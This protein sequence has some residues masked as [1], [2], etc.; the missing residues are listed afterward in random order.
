MK[1]KSVLL[2]VSCLMVTTMLF[3][4]CGPAAEEKE[5]AVTPPEED[6]V[7]AVEEE[8]V[9]EEELI[10]EEEEVAPPKEEETP[11]AK[12]A[13]PAEFRIVGSLVISPAEVTAG[14]SA[15][16]GVD[17]K[18][19]GEVAGTYTVTLKVSGVETDTKTVTLAGGATVPVRFAVVK[20]TVGIHNIQVNSQTGILKV[21]PAPPARY[22]SYADWENGFYISY[23]RGWEQQEG[24]CGLLTI[25]SPVEE[26]FTPTIKVERETLASVM[27][28]AEV[29]VTPPF[30]R[31]QYCDIQ[32]KEVM[33]N[34]IPA[35]EYRCFF[36]MSV[37]GGRAIDMILR[38][39][40][41]VKD[42]T[43]FTITCTWPKEVSGL[44]EDTFDT[45]I[46]SFAFLPVETVVPTPSPE[47]IFEDDFND[48]SS[49]W[50]THSDQ[51]HDGGYEGGEYHILVKK[52]NYAVYTYNT[53]VGQLGDF[54][55]EA[56]ATLVSGDK[57]SDYGLIF[58]VE[59][60]KGNDYYHFIVSGDGYYYLG[61]LTGGVWTDLY[62]KTSSSHINKGYATNHLNLD[63]PYQTGCIGIFLW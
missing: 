20:D 26:H 9:A 1:K 23:P 28:A 16:V 32:G 36:T 14:E 53:E 18:N 39:L 41:L 40:V 55:L 15:T 25:T 11:K 31:L 10:A 30:T 24:R 50:P 48:P 22:Y 21:S 47:L 13:A 2:V 35:V 45:I 29:T 63:F 4:S 34:N 46:G 61:K 59:P 49:G 57:E 38:K 52:A 17:V 6:V 44:Y 54:I 51:Y 19:V 33:I 43:A 7:T 27:T 62:R 37:K 8:D 60:T 12:E 56:D 58:R 5:E 42:K 3:M